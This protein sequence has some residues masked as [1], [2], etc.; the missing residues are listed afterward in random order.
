M[1]E[2][3]P[4]KVFPPERSILHHLGEKEDGDLC[5]VRGF[6]KWAQPRQQIL[7]P[8]PDV[9]AALAAG[10]T[11]EEID[12]WMA[13]QQA[14]AIKASPRA[15]EVAVGT[16]STAGWIVVDGVEASL[17]GAIATNFPPADRPPLGTPAPVF[18]DE[19]W[20][21]CQDVRGHLSAVQTTSR[22]A[23]G[24]VKCAP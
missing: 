12:A 11:Q 22:S 17:A 19:F 6:E 24:A 20:R 1:S 4:G 5:T 13:E 14:A 8:F 2:T 21:V 23:A 3:F 16:T 18:A 7:L 15:V 9:A 10:K